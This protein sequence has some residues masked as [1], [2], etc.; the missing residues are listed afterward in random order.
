MLVASIAVVASAFLLGCALT[1]VARWFAPRIGLVDRPDGGRKCHARP[2]PLMGGVAICTAF[3]LSLLLLVALAPWLS[4]A[5][6]IGD[7]S[8][9]LPLL[10]SA[11]LFCLLG[12]YD[13]RFGL[14]PRYKLA[15][16]IAA[17]LPFAIW[18]GAVMK[19]GV[20]GTVWPLG[21]WSLPFTVFWLVACSNVINLMDGLDGLAGTISCIA[22]VTLA[23]MSILI[24]RGETAL[25][26]LAAAAGV[27]GFLVHNWPPAKIFMGDSGSLT[28]GFLVG[29]FSIEAALKQTA[30]FTLVV[31]LVLISVPVF[32]TAMAI[33][34][35]R[36]SGRGIGE[37]DRGHIHHH[38]QDR[39]LSRVQAL[40]LIAG[41]CAAMAGFGMLSSW[42]NSEMLAL[43]LCATLLTAMV[44]ARVFG[45][46]EAGLAWQHLR[47]VGGLLFDTS[48]A[49]P[50]R[51]AAVRLANVDSV[52]HDD[53]WQLVCG[54]LAE[55]GGRDME[56]R[57]TDTEERQ[58]FYRLAW[59]ADA[60]TPTA[61]DGTW[62]LKHTVLR[63]SGICA[64]LTVNGTMGD[65]PW[66]LQLNE[67]SRLI[68]ALC[69]T[70]P[71]EYL[72][73]DM[74]DDREGDADILRFDDAAVQP[75]Q[76]RALSKEAASGA[77]AK[78]PRAA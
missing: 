5:P 32:D 75:P 60:P 1:A 12:L 19:L 74:R 39:G 70:W 24:G 2:T 54:R 61:D 62:Q 71:L 43:L 45:H 66:G 34:R 67:T 14:R 38:L 27:A 16:Q 7:A 46:Y 68:H 26:A 52:R 42:V 18:G 55:C 49:L 17:C 64:T 30:G 47:A 69:R 23:A 25:P 41:L 53:C 59:N 13:D 22:L 48:R 4:A 56:F 33:L 36:L 11:G 78:P 72:Q 57:F 31:P 58:V 8:S 21:A 3:L 77:G 51:L 76:P 9:L 65:S 10:A 50:S 6:S 15:W 63:D 28:L 40:L 35:R 37:A 44:I 20:L 29:A 73:L